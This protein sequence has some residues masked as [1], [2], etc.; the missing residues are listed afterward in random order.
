MLQSSKIVNMHKKVKYLS[1]LLTNKG[2]PIQRKF[3]RFTY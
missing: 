3:H 2:E 1:E